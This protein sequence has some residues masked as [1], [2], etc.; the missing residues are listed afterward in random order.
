MTTL[1]YLLWYVSDLP[2]YL[3]QPCATTGEDGKERADDP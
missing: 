1:R 3:D 2:V